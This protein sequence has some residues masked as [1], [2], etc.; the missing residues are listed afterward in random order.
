MFSYQSL[1]IRIKTHHQRIRARSRDPCVA[2]STYLFQKQLE[3]VCPPPI[4]FR[5]YNQVRFLEV[6]NG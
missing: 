1:S 3:K 4:V 2:T 5:E 6:R